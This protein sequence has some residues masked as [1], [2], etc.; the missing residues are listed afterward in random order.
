MESTHLKL[1]LTST[2]NTNQLVSNFLPSQFISIFIL[3]INS[4]VWSNSTWPS[5]NPRQLK[6]HFAWLMTQVN[7]Q[8]GN[9]ARFFGQGNLAQPSCL[10]Q[11]GLTFGMTWLVLNLILHQLGS[12]LWLRPSW[13]DLQ[14]RQVKSTFDSMDSSWPLLI[15]DLGQSSIVTN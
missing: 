13:V 12:I 11:L 6:L 7:S 2:F 5:P 10:S 3:G 8:Q 14:S 1:Q 9:M 15:T 4:L